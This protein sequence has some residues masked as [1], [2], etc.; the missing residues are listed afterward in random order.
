MS[1]THAILTTHLIFSTKERRPFLDECVRPRVHGYL[2]GIARELDGRTIIVNGTADH[3]HL[4]V[5]LPPKLAVSDAVRVIKANSSRWIH[6][7]ISGLGDFSW[8]TGF[9]AFSVSKSKLADVQAY[10]ANQER[11]H[12]SVSFQDEYRSFLAHHGLEMD[13]ERGW[14]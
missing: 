14:G 9:G 6:R 1:H 4:L 5:D 7:E 12:A 13:E 11:H 10:I 3:V 2:G 8:Q